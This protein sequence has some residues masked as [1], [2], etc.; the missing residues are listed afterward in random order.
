MFF[1][2]EK[3]TLFLV[4]RT[5]PSPGIVVHFA[6]S[7]LHLAYSPNGSMTSPCHWQGCPKGQDDMVIKCVLK[8]M[9]KID[10]WMDS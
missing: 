2:K 6:L 5:R 10:F 1:T 3:E 7:V 4:C 8:R 9:D